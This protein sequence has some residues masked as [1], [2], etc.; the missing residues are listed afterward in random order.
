VDAHRRPRARRIERL[1]VEREER[2]V[3]DRVGRQVRRAG[4]GDLGLPLLG[5]RETRTDA[6]VRDAVVLGGQQACVLVALAHD[7]VRLPVGDHL[8]DPGK[9]RALLVVGEDRA[10][11]ELVRGVGRRIHRRRPHRGD[12]LVGRL[13]ERAQRQARPLYDRGPRARS[14]HEDLVSHALPGAGERDERQDVAGVAGGREEDAE[15]LHGA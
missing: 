9:G 3:A 2:R 14:G 6:D 4:E 10:D 8:E 12:R 15:S 7:H 11:R 1:R 5:R 13:V